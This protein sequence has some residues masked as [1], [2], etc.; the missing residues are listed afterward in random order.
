MTKNHSTVDRTP[1]VLALWPDGAPGSEAWQQHEQEDPT[2]P[3][4]G[5]RIVRN[6][7]QPTLIAYLPDPAIATGAA[8]IIAPGGGFHFLAIDHE[9]HEVARWLN[10][11]GIAAFILKYRVIPTP[12][13]AAE[14][15]NALQAR[16]GGDRS[17]MRDLTQ[18]IIP[19][20]LADAKQ[21]IKLVRQRAAE[22]G[23]ATDRVGMMGFSA[24][25]RVT[26]GLALDFDS[27]TRPDFVAPIYGALWDEIQVPANAPPLFI[28]LTSDDSLALGNCLTLYSAWQ[29]AGYPAELH[30]YAEGGHGFGMR[31]QGLPVDQWIERFYEWLKTVIP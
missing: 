4:F 3:P 2:F 7:T 21:A 19:L 17:I 31:V 23:I 27:A 9:G 6:I 15:A 24:G 12:D 16:F 13:D 28:A 26:A 1:F 30:I 5:I 25:A 14:F 29:K 18:Q 20:A 8:V 11:R 10:E 22:W